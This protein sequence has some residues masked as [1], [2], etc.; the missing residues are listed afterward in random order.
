MAD[1]QVIAICSSNLMMEVSPMPKETPPRLTESQVRA[2]ATAESFGRGV[3][4]Y[5]DG[6]ILDPVRQGM[7]LRAQCEGSQYEPYRVSATL[8]ANGIVSTS[9]SQACRCR[10]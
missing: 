7:Q 3:S 1:G 6:A 2:L 5:E 8:A 4:Y 9:C 10:L